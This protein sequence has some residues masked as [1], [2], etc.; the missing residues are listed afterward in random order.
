MQPYMHLGWWKW[1]YRTSP[2]TYLL[3]GFVGQGIYRSRRLSLRTDCTFSAWPRSDYLRTRR[4]C[5]NQATPG[6]NMPAISQRIYQHSRWLRPEP[7]RQG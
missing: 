1:M 2:W 3:E 5:Y 6:T 4:I 7:E